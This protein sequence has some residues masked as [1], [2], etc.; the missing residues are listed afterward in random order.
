[1][2][3]LFVFTYSPVDHGTQIN[4][5]SLS[6]DSFGLMTKRF[7]ITILL[8][9]VANE[10]RKSQIKIDLISS[11]TSHLIELRNRLDAHES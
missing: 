4:K 6:G 5:G 10:I 11:F 9:E 8:Q 3:R 7:D 1:M 2:A